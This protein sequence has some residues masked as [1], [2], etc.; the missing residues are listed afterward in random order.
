MGLS[1]RHASY[2]DSESAR[3]FAPG[4]SASQR[5]MMLSMRC[6]C[7]ALALVGVTVPVSLPIAA[8]GNQNVPATPVACAVLRPANGE[9]DTARI[10]QAL[11][12]CAP[13]RAVVLEAGNARQASAFYA[14]P[15]ILP[16]SHTIPGCG[17]NPVCVEESARLRS[18]AW[19]LRPGEELRPQSSDAILQTI[20]LQLS[21]SVQR[22]DGA[23]ND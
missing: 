11:N 8:Q 22:G 7:F 4:K 1:R 19:K 12:A 18:H 10:Q 6:L 15:L 13:G 21:G 5:G 23:W 20:H 14:A 2:V 17:R 16:R 9:Q 3:R